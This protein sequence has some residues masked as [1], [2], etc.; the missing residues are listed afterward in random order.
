MDRDFVINIKYKK[1]FESRGYLF[2]GKYGKFIQ[3]DFSA[4]SKEFPDNL[5]EIGS[6][7]LIFVL[8]CSGSMDGNSIIEAKKA[9][10]I[11]IK[12]LS[13]PT[14]FNIYR[15]GSNFEKLFESPIPCT[16]ENIKIALD[17][18]SKIEADLGGTEVLEPLK[19]I[20]S[21]DTNSEYIR[22]IILISDGEVGNETEVVNLAKRGSDKNRLFTIGIGYGPNEYF[23]RET[24]RI[25]NGVSEL[26]SPG[27]RIEPKILRLFKKVM[28]DNLHDLKI[29]WGDSV[30]QSPALPVVYYGNM[31]SIFGRVTEEVDLP[32]KVRITA[33]AGNMPIEWT[34][35]MHKVNSKDSPIPL[36]WA[37]E[38]IRDM[39]IEISRASLHGSKQKSRKDSL[40]KKKIIKISKEFG[41]ISRETSFIAIEKREDH[42][43]L[44][45]EIIL[46]KVP[47][48]LTK[49][50]GRLREKTER[51][52]LKSLLTPK[53]SRRLKL[54][55]EDLE[56]SLYEKE[57]YSSKRLKKSS[58]STPEDLLINLLSLQRPE[59]GFIIKGNIVRELNTTVSE[60][61]KLSRTIKIKG[62][63]NRLVLLSTFIILAVLK[64]KFI[65][66]KSDWDE[67]VKKSEKWLQKE[68]RRTQPTIQGISL[69]EWIYDYVDKLNIGV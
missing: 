45:R 44:G 11:L 27:E 23:L 26:I 50:W 9:I 20:Y 51:R 47:V 55:A 57:P 53:R 68:I 65:D 59:G 34:I 38:K 10:E 28:S 14:Y 46:R 36:L 35:D 49:E 4:L 58:L 48:M 39:E 52:F 17:Y 12:A 1:D 3:I 54:F 21:K 60:L 62:R 7:E 61:K 13:D 19:D 29:E 18:I 43:K 67:I 33:M 41:I 42:E 66:Q 56:P 25:S 2:N 22:N 16:P 24:A 69:E 40:I 8:D 5:T 37:R 6:K 31:V 64:K 63:I 30:D 32:E 15:F